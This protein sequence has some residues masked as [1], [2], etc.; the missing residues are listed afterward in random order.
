MTAPQIQAGLKR[1]AKGFIA[2]GIAQ[3]VLIIGPGLQ[4]NN[5]D[6]IKAIATSLVFGFI[7]GGLLAVQKM[8]SWT[9]PTITIDSLPQ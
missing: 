5:L 8:Y 4:F 7:V 3:A 9:Q 6:D 1:F 2:G